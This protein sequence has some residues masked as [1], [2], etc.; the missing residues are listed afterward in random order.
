MIFFSDLMQTQKL[1]HRL[2]TTV[3]P[4]G[5]G[6]S[7]EVERGS[8]LRQS[9]ESLALRGS[10]G[11]ILPGKRLARSRSENCSR[12]TFFCIFLSD[13][14]ILS[15]L[16]INYHSCTKGM[17][18]FLSFLIEYSGN[19]CNSCYISRLSPTH[20]SFC[21]NLSVQLSHELSQNFIP[22]LMTTL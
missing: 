5:A 18:N 13:N 19:A 4:S 6:S 22:S 2:D 12:T 17:L 11:S 1:G 10:R 7:Q 20:L 15:T 8:R 16:L 21:N 14:T 3:W 9:W